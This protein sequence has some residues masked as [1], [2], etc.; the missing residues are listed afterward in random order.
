LRKKARID[1]NR[2]S[3][4]VPDFGLGISGD[5]VSEGIQGEGVTPTARLSGSARS[6][7]T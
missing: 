1:P 6:A 2:V 5:F 4:H 7:A 3:V